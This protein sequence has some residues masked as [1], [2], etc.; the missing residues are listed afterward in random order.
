MVCGFESATGFATAVIMSPDQQHVHLPRRAGRQRCGTEGSRRDAGKA[1]WADDK[2]E[3][4]NSQNDSN[5]MIRMCYNDVR[6]I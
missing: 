3:N 5:D 2:L 4:L 6:I 1:G